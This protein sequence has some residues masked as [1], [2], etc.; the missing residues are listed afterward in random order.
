MHS[1]NH[2]KIILQ[3]R[4]TDGNR[5]MLSDQSHSASSKRLLQREFVGSGRSLGFEFPDFDPSFSTSKMF[6]R[7]TN[8]VPLKDDKMIIPAPVYVPEPV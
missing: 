4:K 3:V 1:K 5:Q 2:Y 8:Q 6:G 7:N